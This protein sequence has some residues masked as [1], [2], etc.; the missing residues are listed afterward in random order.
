MSAHTPHHHGHST[1]DLD[2]DAMADHLE[3]EAELRAPF[4]EEAVA[5]L[6]GLLLEGGIGPDTAER[7]LDVGS[8]PGV[9]TAQLA[10]A[11]PQ[12]RV[13]A[14][15]GA[16][17]LLERARDRAER[18]GLS[19]RMEICEAQ[20]PEELGSLGSGDLIWTSNVVHH[21]GDQQAALDALAASLRPGGILAVVERGLQP[22][23]LPRDI[24]VGRP[25]LQARLDAANE[26]WFTGMREGLPGHTPTVED[27]PAMLARAGLTPAG[28]RTFL[29]ELPAPL[30]RRAREHLH[31]QLTRSREKLGEWLDADDL[32]AVDTLMDEEAP[33]GILKRPDAFYLTAST[34]H[35]GRAS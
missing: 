26:E 20:L 2:W 3:R 19:G 5:W 1:E 10:H 17:N 12:A 35:A 30:E 33:T 16:S 27:W 29:T 22:R 15:D 7:L 32:L 6:R 28:S 18:E 14:V 24:G 25:G 11:F 8:G 4:V 13:V 21:I 31:A 23:W 34:V 9:H